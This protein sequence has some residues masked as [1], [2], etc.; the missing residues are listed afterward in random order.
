MTLRDGPSSLRQYK[1]EYGSH[2]RDYKTVH[3]GDMS[4]LHNPS[5]PPVSVGVGANGRSYPNVVQERLTPIVNMSFSFGEYPLYVLF[6]AY[7]QLGRSTKESP[8]LNLNSGTSLRLFYFFEFTRQRRKS[9][10]IETRCVRTQKDTLSIPNLYFLY[11]SKPSLEILPK[12]SPVLL[13]FI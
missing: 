7:S 10:S 6:Q 13:S 4:G 3:N 12:L 8:I 2:R 1:G 5:P 9:T 11:L